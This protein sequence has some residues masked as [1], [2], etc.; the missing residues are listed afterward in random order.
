MPQEPDDSQWWLDDRVWLDLFE[1]LFFAEDTSQADRAAKLFHDLLSEIDNGPKGITNVAICIENALRF[2][3]P[4]TKVGRAC[5]ILFQ[6][7]LG[8]DFPAKADSLAIVSEAIKR[9]R[10]AI[11]GATK[12]QSK[13]RRK[14]LHRS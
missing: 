6:V 8:N 1:P 13:R 11:E 2:V 4:F 14:G 3:F 5:M 7:S 10:V 12:S 9:T